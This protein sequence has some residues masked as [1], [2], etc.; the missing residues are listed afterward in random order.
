MLTREQH[1]RRLNSYR[2]SRE[3][4]E[5]ARTVGMPASLADDNLPSL[6]GVRWEI[7]ERTFTEFR[8]ILP[9]INWNGSSFLMSE[10]CFAGITTKYSKEGDRYFCEF[11]DA[12]KIK[13]EGTS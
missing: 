7:E 10:F 9:P 8:D 1:F 2:V 6:L 11:V 12:S 13:R 3:Y 4:T 5:F